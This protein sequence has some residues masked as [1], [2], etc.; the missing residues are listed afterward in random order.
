MNEMIRGKQYEI[1]ILQSFQEIE[2]IRSF[3]EKIQYHPNTDIDHYLTVIDSMDDIISPYII[4]FS[5]NGQPEA[6]AVGR[7]EKRNTGISFGY[8]TFFS[9]KVTCLVILYAG[10]L[11]NWSSELYI[12][13]V[14]EL[15][16]ALRC[17]TA[18]VVWLNLLRTESDLYNIARKLPNFLCRDHAI[19]TNFH[20]KMIL[21]ESLDAFLNKMTAKHRY[22][23]KRL[24]RVLQKDYPGKVEYKYSQNNEDLEKLFADAEKVAEKSYQRNIGAGFDNSIMQQRLSTFAKKKQMRAYLLYIDEKPCAFWI[25]TLY[26]NTFYLDFTGYDAA[27]K[28]YEPGTILFMRMLEDII[29][30]RATEIDFGFGDAFYKQRFG[31]HNWKE[32]SIYIYAPTMEGIFFNAFRTINLI[33]YRY[34]LKLAART[35]LLQK[36]K[37]Q[38]RNKLVR[39]DNDIAK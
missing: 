4:L 23:L 14:K 9:S 34:L 30:N 38:W 21:P 15:I 28:H 8:K 2:E 25:G 33:P 29:K 17:K 22:W 20:W 27:Y 1:K 37:R 39:G 35:N 13:L 32:S 19:E 18:N 12:S 6:M 36:I 16:N 10:I 26:G 31:D 5:Y 3:W 11:G 24:P 7:L